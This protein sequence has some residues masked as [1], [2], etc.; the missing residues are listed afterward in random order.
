MDL[1]Y[2]PEVLTFGS[3]RNTQ[4]RDYEQ[5]WN[6]NDSDNGKLLYFYL[7]FPVSH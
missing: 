6:R 2:I 5:P 4:Y 1:V 3:F 7:F